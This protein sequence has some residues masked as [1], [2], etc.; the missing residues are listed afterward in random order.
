MRLVIQAF[1]K[2]SVAR[3]DTQYINEQSADLIGDGCLGRFEYAIH[4]CV[5]L[6]PFEHRTL[7]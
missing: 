2:S 1:G 5:P 3:S 4:F 6:A 7:N